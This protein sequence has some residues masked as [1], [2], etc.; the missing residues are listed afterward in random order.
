MSK[1][2]YSYTKNNYKTPPELYKKALETLGIE[3]FNLD[4]CCSDNH[5]PAENYFIKGEK[6][7]LTEEWMDY[8]WCNPPF[9]ECKQWVKKAFEENK[10]DGKTI[11]MLIP[12]RTETEYFHKY[13]LQNPYAQVGFLKK[14]YRF[15]NSAGEQMGVFKNALCLVYF[16]PIP[17]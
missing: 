7:G 2:N 8:T 5:I 6:D 11:V 13:I 9:N 17:F 4:S 15:L 10:K 14:G 12:A 16:Y 3:K 1:Y